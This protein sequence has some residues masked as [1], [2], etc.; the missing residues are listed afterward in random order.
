M[1]PEL[2]EQQQQGE[3]SVEPQLTGCE[4]ELDQQDDSPSV[5]GPQIQLDRAPLSLREDERFNVS[6]DSNNVVRLEKETLL[7][8]QMEDVPDGKPRGCFSDGEDDLTGSEDDYNPVQG[9]AG[10][11]K[12]SCSC[13]G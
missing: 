7:K 12:K 11:P 13:L 1:D 4:E 6:I 10:H 5:E 2:D 8:Q 3:Q 9:Y